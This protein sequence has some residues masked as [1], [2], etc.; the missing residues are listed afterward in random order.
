MHVHA[1]S[2]QKSTYIYIYRQSFVDPW[3]FSDLGQTWPDQTSKKHHLEW[4]RAQENVGN[5]TLAFHSGSGFNRHS[6]LKSSLIS[7]SVHASRHLCHLYHF[8]SFHFSL[9]GQLRA[10]GSS[11]EIT[12]AIVL[13]TGPLTVTRCC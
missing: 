8:N 4:L 5:P 2:V 9:W 6:K 3:N 1:S 10:P 13:A 12:L 11:P 7:M